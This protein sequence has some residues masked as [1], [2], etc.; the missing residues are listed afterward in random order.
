MGMASA[1]MQ[2]AST[3]SASIAGCLRTNLMPSF[4]LVNIES[5]VASGRKRA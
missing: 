1:V 2:N 4:R 5:E 3:I